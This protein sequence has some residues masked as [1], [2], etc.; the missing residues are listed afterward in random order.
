VLD[1]DLD[2]IRA[3]KVA[4]EPEILERN[5]GRDGGSDGRDELPPPRVNGGLLTRPENSA[6]DSFVAHSDALTKFLLLVL[7][8]VCYG[9]GKPFTIGQLC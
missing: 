7:T 6:A 1:D 4:E 2:A 8:H 9:G 5:T 3:K